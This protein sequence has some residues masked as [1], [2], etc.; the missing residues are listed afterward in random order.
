M[1]M[2][3]GG[4]EG[5]G[6]SRCHKNMYRRKPNNNLSASEEKWGRDSSKY[7]QQC[8]QVH[9]GQFSFGNFWVQKKTP[10]KGS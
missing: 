5:E 1:G 2:G 7:A 3:R 10:P 6:V 9:K 8:Q 4:N